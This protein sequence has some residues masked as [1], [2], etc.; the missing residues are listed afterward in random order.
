[1]KQLWIIL[2][3]YQT[4]RVRWLPDQ[5]E[6]SS[7]I[8]E[9]IESLLPMTYCH[10][11][12]LLVG[13]VG[14]PQSLQT[15]YEGYEISDFCETNPLLKSFWLFKWSFSWAKSWFSF[16]KWFNSFSISAF[17]STVFKTPSFNRFSWSKSFK[18]F[19]F[20]SINFL[21]SSRRSSRSFCPLISLLNMTKY[22]TCLMSHDSHNL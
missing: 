22:V 14:C 13:W 20:S 4:V 12:R 11:C 19:S 18:R 6:C 5:H 2:H 16:F 17:F 15:P 9:N 8:A 7:F 3:R 10:T 1:M 21:F